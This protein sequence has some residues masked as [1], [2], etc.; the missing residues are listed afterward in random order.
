MNL[1]ALI[2][3][4]LVLFGG[5]DV[6]LTQ[7]F[8]PQ[9][10]AATHA[11]ARR[12]VALGAGKVYIAQLDGTL[13]ALDRRSGDVVWS[14]RVEPWQSG[15]TITTA[16][17]YVD[18]LVIIGV[19]G[20]EFGSRGRVTAFNAETGK[21]VWRFYTVPGPGQM[22]HESWPQT[23]NVWLRGGAAVWQTPSVD[24]RLG[25]V[26]FST[27]HAGPDN[28][29]SNRAGKNLFSAS[30]VAVD[31]KTGQL[32]W[33]YQMVHH[34][35]WGFS[36]PSPTVLFDAWIDGRFVR[37]IGEA[38]K[39]GRPYLLDR[40]NGKPLFPIPERPVPQDARRKTWPTQPVPKTGELLWKSLAASGLPSSL[41][42]LR[43]PCNRRKAARTGS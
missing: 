22:G 39:T 5:A 32:R 26:Y 37:G 38:G 28:D 19:A 40:T 14:T 10:H 36:A 35:I 33:Y 16:P 18:G 2:A 1:R 12:G 43:S 8:A 7:T 20:G 3:T 34:D 6:V 31:L 13:V 30:I 17:L 9:T 24:P 4:L 11:A 42:S 41:R 21:E 29:G 25:L 27:G 15:Y 23:G